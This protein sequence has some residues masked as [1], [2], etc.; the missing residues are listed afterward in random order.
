[1]AVKGIWPGYAARCAVLSHLPK[2]RAVV[3]PRCARRKKMHG[4]GGMKYEDVN[5]EEEGAGLGGFR[6]MMSPV[7]LKLPP[8]HFKG[9][10]HGGEA[11]CGECPGKCGADLPSQHLRDP[12]MV[13]K[14]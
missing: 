12:M 11:T 10:I 9:A 4:H 5:L 7:T 13:E 2:D 3:L 8:M 14:S 6:T 1:M